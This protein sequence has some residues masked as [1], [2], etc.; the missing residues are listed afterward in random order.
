MKQNW[1]VF[2]GSWTGNKETN[3]VMHKQDAPYFDFTSRQRRAGTLT[4]L[5]TIKSK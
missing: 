3:L 4:Y 1:M 5:D 2:G